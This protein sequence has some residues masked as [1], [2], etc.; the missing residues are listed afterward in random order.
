MRTLYD[1]YA[2][3]NHN[4]TLSFA[5]ASMMYDPWTHVVVYE[6]VPG[7]GL[8]LLGGGHPLDLIRRFGSRI[9]ERSSIADS[10]LRIVVKEPV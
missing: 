6:R 10:I 4:C 5:L 3:Y 9:V 2:Q 8:Q 7:F 1:E